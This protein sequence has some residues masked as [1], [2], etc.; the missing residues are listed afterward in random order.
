MGFGEKLKRA[1]KKIKW[2]LIV[3]TILVLVILIWAIAPIT[4]TIKEAWLLT[5]IE[6]YEDP[7]LDPEE[8]T[9]DWQVAIM[10]IGYYI[11]HPL[12]AVK[13]CFSDYFFAYFY[14]SRWFIA[15]YGLFVFIGI[16]RAFPK[17]EYEDIENGSSDWSENGEQY[18]VLSK[19]KGIILAEKNY[20][21]TNKRGNVN[22]LVV[23]RIWCW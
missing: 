18:Q 3:S 23:R 19:N 22:V 15:F 7:V 1:I 20:L 2:K 14:V 12:S 9:F 21:P 17:H 13:I 10:K 5:Y 16:A 6:G 11:T 4:V 8:N